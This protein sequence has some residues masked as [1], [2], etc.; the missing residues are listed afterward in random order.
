MTSE[1]ENVH[2]LVEN[3]KKRRLVRSMMGERSSREGLE[4]RG[5]LTTVDERVER[6]GLIVIRNGRFVVLLKLF[7]SSRKFFILYALW[8]LES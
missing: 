6:F 5:R 7:V 8:N 2:E 3:S 4:R 1:N